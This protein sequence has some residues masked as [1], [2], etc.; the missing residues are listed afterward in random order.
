METKG[1]LEDR[2]EIQFSTI[3]PL[4]LWKRLGLFQK[5]EPVGIDDPEMFDD[6]ESRRA[7]E[8][9]KS[10]LKGENLA[11]PDLVMISSEKGSLF[12]W[13]LLKEESKRSQKLSSTNHLFKDDVLRSMR[14]KGKK[15]TPKVGFDELD[16]DD[17]TNYLEEKRLVRTSRDGIRITQN[18]TKLFH[19]CYNAWLVS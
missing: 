14:A 10:D 4:E 13:A 2:V 18:F 17:I 12:I 9:F 11:S 3:N 1:K 5:P 19:E 16:F 8:A 6:E 15:M 7:Y